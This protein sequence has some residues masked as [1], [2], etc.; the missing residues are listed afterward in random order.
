MASSDESVDY[1]SDPE[2]IETEI[3]YDLEQEGSPHSS[4][5]D[6]PYVPKQNKGSLRW[7]A[8]SRRRVASTLR[9]GDENGAQTWKKANK[10]AT[11]NSKSPGLVSR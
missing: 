7:R 6:D 2:A 9:R 5:R 1:S 11:R 4:D 10:T 3:E 8:V